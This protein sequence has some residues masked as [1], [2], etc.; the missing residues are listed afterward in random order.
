MAAPIAIFPPTFGVP[1]SNLKEVQHKW[2]S[3]NYK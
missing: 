3:Q 1:A 2:F